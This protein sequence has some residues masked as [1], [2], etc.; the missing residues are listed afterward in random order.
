[1]AS[2]LRKIWSRIGLKI[3]IAPLFICPSTFH[4]I[5]TMSSNPH[6]VVIQQHSQYPYSAHLETSHSSFPIL[7]RIDSNHCDLHLLE[8]LIH[9]PRTLI[10]TLQFQIQ[11]SIIVV[12]HKL[13]SHQHFHLL[14]QHYHNTT[15]LIAHL[16]LLI[17]FWSHQISA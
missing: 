4:A 10:Q 5:G 16:F 17:T 8:I 11:I 13:P 9:G 6:N 3:Y 7:N 12:R 2:M 1:L 15:G 14:P